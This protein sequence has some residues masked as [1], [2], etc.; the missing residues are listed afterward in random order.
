M[1]GRLIESLDDPTAALNLVGALGEPS[2]LRRLA[3]AA[4]AEARAPAEL[5]ASAVRGF[6]DTASDDHWL[7]LVGIMNSAEDPGLAALRAILDKVLPKVPE[8]VHAHVPA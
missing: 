5:I 1:F 2:L 6:L 3:V 4:D 8:P 7:Q